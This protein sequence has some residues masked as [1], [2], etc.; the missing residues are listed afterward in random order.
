MPS[1]GEIYVS[2]RVDGAYQ[3]PETLGA[4]V[5]S[6]ADEAM[7]FIAPDGSYLLFTRFGHEENHGFADLWISFR[8]DAGEGT[9]P[10]NLGEAINSLAGICSIVSPD[11]SVLFFNGGGDDYWVDAGGIEDRRAAS[12]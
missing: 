4:P 1:R 8:D 10:L 11:G 5:N 9:Q 6:D 12:K 7:P 3:E 2:R